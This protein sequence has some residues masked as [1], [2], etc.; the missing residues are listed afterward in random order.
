MCL[1]WL[2][3]NLCFD[4]FSCYDCMLFIVVLMANISLCRPEQ[5]SLQLEAYFHL[6][7]IIGIS[8]WCSCQ[9]K[10]KVCNVPAD[11]SEN[12]LKWWP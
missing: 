12:M 8:V 7:M 11:D 9:I 3:F 2:L 1:L 10:C 4:N 6:T 5:H